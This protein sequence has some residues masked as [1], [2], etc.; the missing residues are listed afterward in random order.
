MRILVLANRLDVDGTSG[1][2]CS[3]KLVQ[4][5]HNRGHQLEV[6]CAE[7]SE[8]VRRPGYL[9]PGLQIRFLDTNQ[10]ALR[11]RI[12]DGLDRWLGGAL[13]RVVVQMRGYP[14]PMWRAVAAWR[15]L[16]R[17]RT[18]EA[19]PD[20][21]VALSSGLI[22]APHMALAAESRRHTNRLPWLGYI[23]D[24]FPVSR[25]PGLRRATSAWWRG[26]YAD[27]R[28]AI[29]QRQIFRTADALAFPSQRLLEWA[30]AEVPN[31]SPAIR[32]KS[33]VV[34]H[35]A[36]VP[37]PGAADVAEAGRLVDGSRFQV[38]HAGSLLAAQ[39]VEALLAA[40]RDFRQASNDRASASIVQLGATNPVHE[41]RPTWQSAIADGIL[42]VHQRRVPHTVAVAATKRAP[43]CLV[44]DFPD[45][46]SPI[47]PGKVAD[48]VAIDAPIL[49]LG[50]EQS[51]TLD[52]L[53]ADW[54]FA[55]CP[56]DTEGIRA[57]LEAAWSRWIAGGRGAL[58]VPARNRSDLVEPGI[59]D[60]FVR[61]V[62]AAAGAARRNASDRW[63][64]RV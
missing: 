21:A 22:F 37:E 11:R 26:R 56:D 1:G 24:P 29:L 2:L 17:S 31:E 38:L 7:A 14:P 34:P 39:T 4:V 64:G 49:Y 57:A 55:A 51:A 58:Q 33:S 60:A 40:F 28:Q 47:L 9:A 59:G 32:S 12:F 16:L 42:T 61:A 50:P 25:M 19:R 23:H 52:V 63:G 5:L 45:A 48:L 15:G 44:V 6:W 41:A 8:S 13:R 35:V 62:E 53:G 46:M 30:A 36:A 20:V 27:R 3:A 43:L 18:D 10:P 54:P